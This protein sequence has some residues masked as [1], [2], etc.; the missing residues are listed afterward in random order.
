MNRYNSHAEP[1]FKTLEIIKID[2]LLKVQELVFFYKYRHGVLPVYLLN[3]N[4]IPNYNMHSHDTRRA[5]NILT[6]MTKHEFAK[7][8]L[9]QNLPHTINDTPELVLEKIITH[10]LH[11]FEYYLKTS[12]LQRY[13]NACTH[14]YM[15]DT[16]VR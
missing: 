9:K 3:W 8:C 5:T 15:I 16:Y 7:K 13:H 2:D 11:G 6:S 4:T 1:L 10:S 12:L 14:N